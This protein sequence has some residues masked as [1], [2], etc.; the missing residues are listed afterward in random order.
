MGCVQCC[1]VL[2][3]GVASLAIIAF[4]GHYFRVGSIDIYKLYFWH[5]AFLVVL[6]WI[7]VPVVRRGM[8]LALN[9]S[10]LVLVYV[11]LMVVS[12][13]CTMGMT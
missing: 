8:S 5:A 4:F 3:T 13:L 9:R 2:C 12:S 11:M 1:A 6:L 10:E 7:S